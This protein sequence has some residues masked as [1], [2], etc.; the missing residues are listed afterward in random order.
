MPL[1]STIELKINEI[2]LQIIFGA[3]HFHID[4]AP[5]D[6]YKEICQIP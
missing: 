6:F 1:V 3:D 4:N 2:I 5:L